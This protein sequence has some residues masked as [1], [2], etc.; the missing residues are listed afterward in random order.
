MSNADTIDEI[1]AEG[2]RLLK[3]RVQKALASITFY[4]QLESV[5]DEDGKV[6]GYWLEIPAFAVRQ[7]GLEAG[8]WLEFFAIPRPEG[9]EP[10][11]FDVEEDHATP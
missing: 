3:E 1:K 5:E 2:Q 10:Q 6:L 4:G 11:K 7:Y 8:R 9:W